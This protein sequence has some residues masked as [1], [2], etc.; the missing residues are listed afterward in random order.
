M[1]TEVSSR[2]HINHLKMPKEVVHERLRIAKI[3]LEFCTKVY[4][5]QL[6]HGRYVLHEHLA[7]ATSWSEG[8]I[9]RIPSNDGVI[10]VSTD[11]CQYG[12]VTHDGSG[13][14]AVRQA[15]GFMT[16]APCIVDKFRRKCLNILSKMRHKHITLE[17]NRTKATQVYF[18]GL[19]R[20][21]CGGG[22]D[23]KSKWIKDDNSY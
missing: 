2:M 4:A 1:C 19:C 7:A 3:H 14:G 11:Q 16:N 23:N 6:H 13:V 20:A 22:G 18:D 15:T 5:M 17:G 10:R 8:C 21:I 12:L 9:R